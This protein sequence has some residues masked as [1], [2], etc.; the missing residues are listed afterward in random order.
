MTVPAEKLRSA[1]G[2][3][4]VTYTETSHPLAIIDSTLA[5]SR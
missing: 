2:L 1:L 4:S 3:T 5:A